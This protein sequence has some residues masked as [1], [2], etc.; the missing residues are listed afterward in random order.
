M[1]NMEY[2][3]SVRKTIL[4]LSGEMSAETIHDL[5]QYMSLLVLQQ[6]IAQ[7]NL[8]IKLPSFTHPCD[9]SLL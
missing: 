4:R 6:R 1:C 7:K 5:T 9:F 8:M 3:I 2:L